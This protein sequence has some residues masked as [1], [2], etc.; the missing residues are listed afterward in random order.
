MLA[1]RAAGADAEQVESLVT[2][3]IEQELDEIEERESLTDLHHL[4]NHLRFSFAREVGGRHQVWI[5]A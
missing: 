5:V 3:K 1:Q 4:L 2:E